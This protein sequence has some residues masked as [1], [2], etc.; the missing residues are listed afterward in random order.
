MQTLGQVSLAPQ[1][2]GLEEPSKARADQMTRMIEDATF[3]RHRIHF[4]TGPYEAH[5]AP[6]HVYEL[7]DLVDAYAAQK[8]P[9]RRV[10][11]IVGALVGE[12]PILTLKSR[13]ATASIMV[14]RSELQH[15][16]RR[17]ALPD[18][19]L[20]QN[21]VGSKSE[22]QAKPGCRQNWRYK[23]ENSPGNDHIKTS[24]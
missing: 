21:D 14:H 10:P 22:P 9:Q 1:T 13:P 7:W 2:R 8:A 23:E 11:G 19:V 24:F 12:S 4:G 3:L 17:S 15:L 20:G 18:P 16:K 5:L 6:Q